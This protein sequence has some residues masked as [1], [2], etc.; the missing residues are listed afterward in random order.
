ML[1]GDHPLVAEAIAREVGIDVTLV[2]AEVPPEGK[3]AYLHA[4]RSAGHRVAFVGDG[5]ND[6]PALAAA[7]LGIAVA[8]ASDVAREAAGLVLLRTNLAAAM[9]LSDLI[10]VGNALL[11]ARRSPAVASRVIPLRPAPSLPPS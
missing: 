5:I 8:R 10:V 11:L 1:S 9:G 6:G 4:Q 2:Q 7:D 3:S